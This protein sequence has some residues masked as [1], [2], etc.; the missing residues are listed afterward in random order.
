MQATSIALRIAINKLRYALQAVNL[1]VSPLEV[2]IDTPRF[3]S[4]LPILDKIN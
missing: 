1:A 4:E 2:L 3:T